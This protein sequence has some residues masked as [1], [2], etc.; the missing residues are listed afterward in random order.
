MLYINGNNKTVAEDRIL[1]KSLVG[2]IEMY[3]QQI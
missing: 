3:H 1:L 2:G